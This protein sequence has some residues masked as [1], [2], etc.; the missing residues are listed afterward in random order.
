MSDIIL[1]KGNIKNVLKR[2]GAYKSNLFCFGE[3]PITKSGVIVSNGEI[4]SSRILDINL[5]AGGASGSM[6][7]YS[8]NYINHIDVKYVDYNDKE[9][10][11][12][13]FNI[14]DN[15][16]LIEIVKFIAEKQQDKENIEK[17]EKNQIIFDEKLKKIQQFL[18]EN[19][20]QIQCIED[21]K[22]QILDMNNKLDVLL[23]ERTLRH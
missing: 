14:L 1:A 10:K 20:E 3:D 5:I 22:N 12:M 15:D 19:K 2:I 9:I 13:S 23:S 6:L 17:I 11:T 16:A 7:S 21:L 4:I 18:I 8:K